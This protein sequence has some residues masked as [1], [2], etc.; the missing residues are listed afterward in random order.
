VEVEVEVEVA[1]EAL[2][3]LRPTATCILQPSTP[4]HFN[5]S[6]T[7][8]HTP[9]LRTLCTTYSSTDRLHPARLPFHCD[10]LVPRGICQT[11]NYDFHR[12]IQDIPASTSHT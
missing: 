9:E 11:L 2:L 5:T 10:A 12:L 4:L 7:L 3:D 1:V 6:S 8:V